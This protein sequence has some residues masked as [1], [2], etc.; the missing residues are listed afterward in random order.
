MFPNEMSIICIR[1]L[2]GHTLERE[3]ERERER[4]GGDETGGSLLTGEFMN[5]EE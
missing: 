2:K 1:D 5:V 4:G 3:R